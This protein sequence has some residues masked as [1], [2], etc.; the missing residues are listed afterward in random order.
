MLDNHGSHVSLDGLDYANNNGLTILSFPPLQPL[1]RSVYGP[2]QKYINTASD[3]WILNHPGQTMT[4]YDIPDI[5]KTALP[6]A[7]TQNNIPSGYL[8]SG[9]F[10]FSRDIFPNCEYSPSYV[11]DRQMPVVDERPTPAQSSLRDIESHASA[12]AQSSLPSTR[13]SASGTE[14]AT[15]RSPEELRPFPKAGPRK[16][17][18]KKL[19]T[20]TNDSQR[21]SQTRLLRRVS[22]TSIR[23]DA[24]AFAQRK[25][26]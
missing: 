20:T 26:N 3:S 6:L 13:R 1:D 2:L 4:L 17:A 25:R 5:V 22:K 24:Y 10:P 15:P 9:I 23:N 12:P 11:T 14:N 18:P 21:F 19:Q 7:M 16:N 8:V